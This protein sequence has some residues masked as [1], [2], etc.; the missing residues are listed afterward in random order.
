MC[1]KQASPY[2]D[3]VETPCTT[4]LRDLG[5]IL[6]ASNMPHAELFYYCDDEHVV[7]PE[8]EYKEKG[9]S[10]SGVPMHY[11]V[12]SSPTRET[13]PMDCPGRTTPVPV[14]DPQSAAQRCRPNFASTLAANAPNDAAKPE[15][16]PAGQA[17][18][19]VEKS[20]ELAETRKPA[21]EPP[22]PQQSSSPEPIPKKP[23]KRAPKAKSTRNRRKVKDMLE[24][25]LGPCFVHNRGVVELYFVIE[26][27]S[28]PGRMY[29]PA[30]E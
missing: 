28:T 19:S 30:H 9:I 23:S 2:F 12:A 5:Q 16:G 25:H 22:S 4:E 7:E 24:D 18:V 11:V 27:S 29:L 15:T 26:I 17:A 20:P 21:D 3:D 8:K 1:R 14:Q 13:S 10:S 6:I